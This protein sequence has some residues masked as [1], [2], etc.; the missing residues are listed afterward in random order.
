[1]ELNTEDG[2]KHEMEKHYE[3]LNKKLDKLNMMHG[4]MKIKFFYLFASK[5]LCE[6]SHPAVFFRL[7]AFILIRKYLVCSL[8]YCCCK[9]V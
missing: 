7:S 6:S 1:M 8:N 2:L 9:I 3:N 5:W 4:A